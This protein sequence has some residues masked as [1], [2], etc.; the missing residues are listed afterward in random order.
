[1]RL[2]RDVPEAKAKLESGELSLTNAAKIQVASQQTLKAKLPHER[3]SRKAKLVDACAGLSQ[4]ECDSKLFAELPGLRTSCKATERKRQV[5]EALTELKFVV[6]SEFCAKIER[7]LNLLAHTNPK[8]SMLQLFEK[9]VD[10]E[11]ALIEKKRGL[12]SAQ[13]SI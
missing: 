11:L 7:L 2:A 6:S 9:L 5:D 10:Q 8:K 4:S 13:L 12:D 1:M 3:M